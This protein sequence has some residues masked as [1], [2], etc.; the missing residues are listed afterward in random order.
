MTRHELRVQLE[1]AHNALRDAILPAID[2]KVL[3]GEEEDKL[4]SASMQIREV[5]ESL[6]KE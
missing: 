2:E 5:R 4:L 3:T 6:N 1:L